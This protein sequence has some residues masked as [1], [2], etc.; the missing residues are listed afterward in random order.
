MATL[1]QIMRCNSI[2]QHRHKARF[3]AAF[4]LPLRRFMD[5]V[6]GFDVVGFDRAIHTPQGVSCSAW[7]KHKYGKEAEALVAALVS[8]I[9]V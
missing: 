3:Q 4:K 5:P 2:L 1:K 6:C 8:P 9:P 7:C